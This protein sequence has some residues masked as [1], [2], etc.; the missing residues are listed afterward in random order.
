MTRQLRRWPSDEAD[1]FRRIPRSSVNACSSASKT[2][3]WRAPSRSCRPRP[4]RAIISSALARADTVGKAERARPGRTSG[5]RPA[6]G[7][8]PDRARRS[9]RRSTASGRSNPTA[10]GT[11]RGSAAARR[12][13]RPRGSRD[14]PRT[15]TSLGSCGVMLTPREDWTCVLSQL[16]PPPDGA[17]MRSCDISAQRAS[18]DAR[19]RGPWPGSEATGPI[20]RFDRVRT[21]DNLVEGRGRTIRGSPTRPLATV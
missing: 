19:L 10:S 20:G 7:G 1:P 12:A 14:R 3:G 2:S 6:A 16:A 9:W 21:L 8:P 18:R 15:G 11:R 4:R 5:G 13:W 17:M